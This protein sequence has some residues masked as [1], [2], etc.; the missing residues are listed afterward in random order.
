MR[1]FLLILL[2]VFTPSILSAEMAGDLINRPVDRVLAHFRARLAENPGDEGLSF[3]LARIHSIAYA[4][5]HKSEMLVLEYEGDWNVLEDSYRVPLEVSKTTN[6]ESSRAQAHLRKALSLYSE[7]V[8]QHPKNSTYLLGYGWVLEQS[9]SPKA[10]ERQYR[11]ALASASP[12]S[13]DL[14]SST[15]IAAKS[16]ARAL[17]DLLPNNHPD[18]A[19]IKK[20]LRRLKKLRIATP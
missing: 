1:I 11:K 16:A 2:I 8:S 15:V 5:G 7:L 18:C 6:A 3:A 13:V 20:E 17:L 19:K 10:A 4:N 12:P 9:N 14:P